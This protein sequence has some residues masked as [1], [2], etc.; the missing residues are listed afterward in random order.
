[1][2]EQVRTQPVPLEAMRRSLDLVRGLE[3]PSPARSQRRKTL[4]A[5]AAVAAMLLVGVLSWPE[6]KVD[7]TD[8]ADPAGYGT[9][10]TGVDTTANTLLLAHKGGEGKIHL[11]PGSHSA[12]TNCCSNV[13]NTDLVRVKEQMALISHKQLDLEKDK[14]KKVYVVTLA[15]GTTVR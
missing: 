7:I 12:F 2:V 3:P 14:V 6:Q 15:N 5:L 8:S 9:Q 10:I 4:R 11:C 13:E 1:A